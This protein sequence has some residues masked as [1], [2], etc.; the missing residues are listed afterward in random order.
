LWIDSDS[1]LLLNDFSFIN[2]LPDQAELL[3]FTKTELAVA[4]GTD[5]RVLDFFPSN[6][7]QLSKLSL[8]HANVLFALRSEP[9]YSNVLQWWARCALD[10]E[11]IAPVWSSVERCLPARQ[12]HCHYNATSALNLLLANYH[13]FNQASYV[14][15]GGGLISHPNRKLSAVSYLIADTETSHLLDI[16][17]PTVKKVTSNVSSMMQC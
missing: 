6:I 10:E 17:T 7:N 2:N 14:L 3:L 15:E 5:P 8:Y 4:E 12:E 11:C 9:L 13:S 16:W 1:H